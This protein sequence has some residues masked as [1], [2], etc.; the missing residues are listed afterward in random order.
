MQPFPNEERRA[1]GDRRQ[2]ATCV[3]D[4]LV[5]VGRRMFHR[6]LHDHRRAY[7]VDRFSLS[8]LLLILTLLI[9]SI[10]DAVI[11]INLLA[12]GCGEVNPL[13]AN[14]LDRGVVPFLVG[15]YIL[16]AAGLPVLLIFQNFT[17]F[18]T[19]FR[20]FYLLPTLVALYVFLLAYQV[21]L[22]H[23]HVGL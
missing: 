1:A 20:V 7:F 23:T 13:M 16:T 4:T 12:V 2:V 8:T 18:G 17:L 15:K 5:G 9:L 6:R 21:S 19:R 11:T 22:L 3:L 10:V 14:L